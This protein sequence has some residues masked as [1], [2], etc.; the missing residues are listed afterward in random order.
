MCHSRRIVLATV[1]C[2]LTLLPRTA[3]Y[4]LRLRTGDGVTTRKV[5]VVR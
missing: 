1:S 4:L 2:L 5:N 3:A